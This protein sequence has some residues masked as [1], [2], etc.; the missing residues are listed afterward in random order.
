MYYLIS[1]FSIEF[2]S[3][4][5]FNSFSIKL[6]QR[7][8]H[9]ADPTKVFYIE[10]IILFTRSIRFCYHCNHIYYEGY[11]GKILDVLLIIDIIYILRNINEQ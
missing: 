2:N 4:F 7:K 9:W 3:K 5:Y 6:I 8:L 1:I 11:Y 10:N